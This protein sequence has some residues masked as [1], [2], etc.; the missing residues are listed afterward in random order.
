MSRRRTAFNLYRTPLQLAIIALLAVMLGRWAFQADYLPDFET[1]C[2]LGGMQALASFA[3]SN[4]LACS[5]TAMQI[6][7]G[8]ALAA[9]VLLAGKLFCS[10]LCPLGTFTEWLGR[11]GERAGI[12]ITPR[13]ITDRLLR[14]PKYAL[15]FATF[16]FTVESSE[17]FCRTF[18][19]YYAALTGYS[20]DV[21]VWYATSALAILI[22]G[23]IFIRQ[24]WC[25]YLCPLGAVTNLFA[26]AIPA[27]GLTLVWFCANALGANLSW[28]WLLAAL[29]LLGF[30]LEAW[31][32]Q[33][34]AFP[35]MKIRRVDEVCTGCRKCDRACPMAIAI[36]E[37]GPVRHIDCHLCTDCVEACPERGALVVARSSRPWAPAAVTIAL[38]SVGLFLG[39]TIHIPTLNQRW[40]DPAA[41]AR[42]Q[43]VELT[44]MKSVKCFG[45]SSSFATRM[46]NVAG[47][48]G[49][50]TYVGDRTVRIWY[51]PAATTAA[52]VRAA[53]F[54]PTR[55]VIA[56]PPADAP[57][58]VMECGIDKLFDPL[59]HFALEEVLIQHGGV[60]ALETR[61]GEPVHATI[62]YDP[63]RTSPD[64]LKK[65][66]E[67]EEVT[68]ETK[69]GYRTES[70]A[71]AVTAP[72]VTAATLRGSD[73]ARH[74]FEPYDATCNTWGSE[75]TLALAKYDIPTPRVETKRD[76]LPYL[77][78]HMSDDPG[79]VRL[80]TLYGAS[81]PTLRFWY[82]PSRTTPEAI[83][84]RLRLP[85]LYVLFD[86]DQTG[87]I[88]N[89][90]K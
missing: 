88:P 70:I 77:V 49:V 30:A 59:D 58:A 31:R 2:P 12:R 56:T 61:F 42:A 50:E 64:R 76:T 74:F 82:N 10:M 66:I 83:L 57:V 89:P 87:Y 5:M 20:S 3:Y 72:R 16:Y 63:T 22:F 8:I 44:G 25:K 53:V 37:T 14:A 36:S 39:A 40:G 27:A 33:G 7:M 45:S 73:L 67:V 85:R 52:D 6:A 68:W 86:N 62:W 60:H 4:T 29:C 23:S 38:V 32:M 11:I 1:Y 13:G 79:I 19:P 71:F 54:V 28:I 18:D 43:M 55:Y 84:T 48:T 65:A 34:I 81:G 17:L 26:Y 47:V 69:S 80:Q 78:S 51:D 46:R 41:Q 24:A 90:F 75:D 15:L 21:N 9:G 35:G